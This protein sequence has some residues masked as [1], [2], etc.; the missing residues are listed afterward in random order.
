M[1]YSQAA[2]YRIHLNNTIPFHRGTSPCSSTDLFITTTQCSCCV[3]RHLYEVAE[4]RHRAPRLG[5][6]RPQRCTF[7][8]ARESCDSYF[9]AL[10]LRSPPLLPPASPVAATVAS[11]GCRTTCL[12]HRRASLSSPPPPRSSLS[13]STRSFASLASSAGRGLD[14]SPY[15]VRRRSPGV[16]GDDVS[17][18]TMTAKGTADRGG[19]STTGG[20]ER[21]R[22]DRK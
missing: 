12:F 1:R 22:G 17:D 5:L 11:S 20:P 10:P 6:A 3:R 21:G 15:D 2:S 18:S 19:T 9:H 4:L 8:S 13:M 14:R 7:V 16:T